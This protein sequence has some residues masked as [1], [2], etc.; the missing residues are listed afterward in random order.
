MCK[1]DS[2]CLEC[3]GAKKINKLKHKAL[4][5]I[6]LRFDTRAIEQICGLTQMESLILRNE[7]AE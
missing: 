3:E 6:F 4:K 1:S 2:V 7:C 5:N